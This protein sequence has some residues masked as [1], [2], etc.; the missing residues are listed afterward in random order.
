[1]WFRS[2]FFI[3]LST[4]GRLSAAKKIRTELM[5]HLE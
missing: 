1:M 2:K 3:L 4:V 5:T